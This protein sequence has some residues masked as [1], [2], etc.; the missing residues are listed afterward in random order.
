MGYDGSLAMLSEE[1]EIKDVIRVQ[2]VRQA[3]RQQGKMCSDFL[4]FVSERAPLAGDPE[5]VS[6]EGR[7]YRA[8]AFAT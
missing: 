3:R 5:A 4:S 2:L 8:E 7:S 1:L 6:R